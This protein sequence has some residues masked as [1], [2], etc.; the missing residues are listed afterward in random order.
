[1]K[2]LF[3]GFATLSVCITCLFSSCLSKD[4]GLDTIEVSYGKVENSEIPHRL[5]LIYLIEL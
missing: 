3:L 4:D 5:T 1:M 2:N